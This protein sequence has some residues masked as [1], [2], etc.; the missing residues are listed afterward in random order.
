MPLMSGPGYLLLR[1]LSLC[2][3]GSYV[4]QQK[5][6]GFV[7]ADEPCRHACQLEPLLER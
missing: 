1:V 7:D 6:V 3:L 5:N 4:L 2:R